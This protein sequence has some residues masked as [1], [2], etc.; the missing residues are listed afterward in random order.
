MRTSI[1]LLALALALPAGAAEHETLPAGEAI[2]SGDSLYL[3]GGTFTKED[4][5]TVGLERFRG[6]PVLI[7][8]FYASCPQACPMLV[9]DLKRVERAVP[10]GL[11]ERLQVVLV[12]LDPERDTPEKMRALLE[13]HQVDLRRWSALRT[14]PAKVQELAAVLGIRYRFAPGGAIHHSTV[15]ALLD[16]EGVVVGRLDGLGEPEGPLVEK[17]LSL[18]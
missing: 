7:S 4:G 9:A 6:R 14:D 3:L 13:A 12:T 17:L 10:P 2:P 18:R 5:T 15:I 16:A 1:L 8:M 11:R